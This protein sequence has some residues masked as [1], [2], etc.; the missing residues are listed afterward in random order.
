MTIYPPTAPLK[1][2]ISAAETEYII[3]LDLII[4]N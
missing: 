2:S 4:R 1:L 3:Y